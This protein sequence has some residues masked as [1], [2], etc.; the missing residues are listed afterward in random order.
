MFINLFGKTTNLLHRA[1]DLRATKHQAITS[2]I[3]NQDTPFYKAKEM[4]VKKAMRDFIPPPVGVPISTTN[5]AHFSLTMK[6]VQTD[7]RHIPVGGNPRGAESYVEESE[8]KTTRLDQNNVNAE[9]QMAQMAE[10]QL[11][12]NAASQMISGKFTGLKNAIR[13]GR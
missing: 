6:L 8:D 1:L 12:F 5:A 7:L 2:N 3:A 10:N 11:M 4:N 9:Q 13:E